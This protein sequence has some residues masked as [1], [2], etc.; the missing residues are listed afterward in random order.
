MLIVLVMMNLISGCS[1]TIVIDSACTSFD[2]IRPSRRD[3]VET[4]RQVVIHNTVWR[5]QCSDP[6]KLDMGG[7]ND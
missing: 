7:D 3:T 4:K 2:I 1:Q 5:K 6:K